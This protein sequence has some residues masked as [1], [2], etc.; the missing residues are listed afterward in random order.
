MA[1]TPSSEQGPSPKPGP[2]PAPPV[3]F[4]W[5]KTDCGRAKYGDLAARPGLPARLRL[6]WFVLIAAIRDWPL[7]DPDRQEPQG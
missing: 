3:A 5:I 6:A 2:S 4:R 1:P 7:P